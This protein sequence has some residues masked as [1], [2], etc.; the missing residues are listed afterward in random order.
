MEQIEEKNIPLLDD[1][2]AVREQVRGMDSEELYSMIADLF[3][4]YDSENFQMGVAVGICLS[5]I[6]KRIEKEEL[7]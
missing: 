2:N 7:N 4:Q 6:S 1:F 3:D 5:E